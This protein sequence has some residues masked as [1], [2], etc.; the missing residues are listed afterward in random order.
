MKFDHIIIATDLSENCGSAA[1][2]A[3]G[4]KDRLGAKIVVTH[5][6]EMTVKNWISSA[7]DMFEDDGEARQRAENNVRNWYKDMTG[8]N[9][10]IVQVRGGSVRRQLKEIDDTLRGSNLVVMNASGRSAVGRFFLGS[11]VRNVV[12]APPCPIVI[13]HPEHDRLEN[14]HPIVVGTDFSAN[15]DKAIEIAVQFGHLTDAT[16]DIVHANPMPPVL[17]FD[18]GDIPVGSFEQAAL[19]WSNQQMDELIARHKEFASIQYSTTI[20]QESP[21]TALASHAEANNSSLV[22]LGHSGES[23]LMQNVL[24]SVAQRT[25]NSL[26]CT[27]IIVPHS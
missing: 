2:W 20:S 17:V 16:I 1:R 23:E 19:E 13:V 8:E 6:I 11:N 3:A 10:D 7:F 15:A 27:L 9:P 18:G 26:P 14:K 5:I 12:A 25:L 22:I 4:V 24:G 21:S